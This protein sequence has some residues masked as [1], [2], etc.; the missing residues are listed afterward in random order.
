MI[1]YTIMWKLWELYLLQQSGEEPQNKKLST[2]SRPLKNLSKSW[3]VSCR[4]D[5]IGSRGLTCW[6]HWDLLFLIS[7]TILIVSLT[8]MR[9]FLTINRG[10]LIL[11]RTVTRVER[12]PAVALKILAIFANI[13][14][15]HAGHH[16]GDDDDRRCRWWQVVL[17]AGV[18]VV[19]VVAADWQIL[20]G[21][22]VVVGR[23]KRRRELGEIGD[24]HTLEHGQIVRLICM[25]CF[26]CLW[27]PRNL[28]A[29][30][31]DAIV[32][33]DNDDAME[34]AIKHDA[35]SCNCVWVCS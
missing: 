23:K 32:D 28:A 10:L 8:A 33:G 16:D 19:T 11:F 34:L 2:D 25:V 12:P 26:I 15:R 3:Y 20:N 31:D 27:I 4:G 24:I 18:A 30:N 21:R 17:L 1:V 35:N 22:R 29:G 13:E 6:P 7:L 14:G 9:I 5:R